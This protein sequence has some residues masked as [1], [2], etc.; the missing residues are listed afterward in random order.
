MKKAYSL[1]NISSCR[2]PPPGKKMHQ[3]KRRYSM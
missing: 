1:D 3:K 2:Y